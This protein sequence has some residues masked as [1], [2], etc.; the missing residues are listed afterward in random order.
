MKFKF[1]IL[2]K[3][4]FIRLIITF[5]IVLIPIYV[6]GLSIYN[7]GINTVRQEMLKSMTAQ[8]EFYMG[9]LENDIQRIKILQHDLF[10]DDDLIKLSDTIKIMN[11]YEKSVSILRLQQRLI[12]IKSSSAYINNVSVFIE[13][14]NKMISSNKA[15][16][17]L[18]RADFNKNKVEEYFNPPQLFFINGG[19]YIEG[20]YPPYVIKD[21]N[22]SYFQVRIELSKAE[23]SKALEQFNIYEGG[24]TIL[25]DRKKQEIV[26]NISGSILNTE[27]KDELKV[28]IDK[29]QNEKQIVKIGSKNYLLMRVTSQYLNLTL[30]RFTPEDE[31]FGALRKYQIWFWLF[32]VLSVIIMILLSFFTYRFIQKPLKKLIH[33]FRKLENGDINISISHN[34]EDE[35]GQ[36][37][38]SFNSMV[39]KLNGLIE[40]VYK[41]KIL[42]QSAK[43]KQLQSQINPHF[44][45]NSFYMLHRMIKLEDYQNSTLVSQKLGNY[46]KFITRNDADEV[47]LVSEVEHAQIYAEMQAMRFSNRI[48]I[49]FLKLPEEF[50]EMI[51][52]RL[53]LQPL[54]EN[55]FEYGLKDIEENGRLIVE[56]NGIKNGISIVVEDNGDGLSDSE[57]EDLKDRLNMEDDCLECTGMINIHRRLKLK[58]GTKSGIRLDRSRFGGLKAEII[59]IILKENEN[60]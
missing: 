44:L 21:I 27:E 7:W 37:Y 4:I 32:S 6:M 46:F 36:L 50:S 33:S 53:I 12:T 60:V 31:A 55:A 18:S 3:S 54:I 34:H 15:V 42:T 38:G 26:E 9:N 56:F 59:I 48:K 52:P 11:E 10:V 39:Y 17:S 24:G 41:Q 2:E 25:F 5:F 47:K 58:F 29:S 43:L 49:E 16:D 22:N 19:I 28:Q 20:W 30:L 51:V 1:R 57:L 45:Y 13:S 8:V 35:F 14:L 23:I 40:Q